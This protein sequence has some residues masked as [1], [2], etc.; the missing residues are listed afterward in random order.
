[1]PASSPRKDDS[2]LIRCGWALTEPELTYHDTEWGV[3]SHDDRH[4]FE[5]LILE[6]AQAGLSWRTILLKRDHY[7]K[8]FANFDAARVARFT[9][10][11]LEKLLEDP[12]IVRNRLKVF[13]A[14][15]NARVFLEM[16]EAYGSFSGWLW[17][18][19]DG[20]P[21]VNR[22]ASYRDNPAKTELSDRISKDLKKRGMTFVGSTIIYAYLQSVGVVDDHAA[23]CFR[24][25]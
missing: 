23:D 18:W 2:S 8:V 5:M 19:V 24:A 11:K 21:I 1:M 9:D 25:K 12:G 3:P 14:R 10:R 6:G 17:D 16:V 20:K 7:R 4:L 13:A 15:T 22:P